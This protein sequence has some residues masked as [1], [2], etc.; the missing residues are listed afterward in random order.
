MSK[1]QGLVLPEGFGKLKNAFTSSGLEPD[2][3]RLGA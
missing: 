3:I 1:L 2:T